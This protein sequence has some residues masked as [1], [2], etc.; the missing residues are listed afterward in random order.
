VRESAFLP[1]ANLELSVYRVTG[2]APEEISVL[3][4]THGPKVKRIFGYA[5]I[6]ADGV[7]ALDLVLS[8]SAPPPRHVNIVGWP[9]NSDPDVQKAIHL[10]KAKE[11]A[12]R[13]ALC[14]FG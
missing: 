4:A 3:G 12:S 6:Q 1:P 10:L 14:L 7:T 11:L 8:P 2:L 9:L 13:A 5:Q